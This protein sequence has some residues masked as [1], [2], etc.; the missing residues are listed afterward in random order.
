MELHKNWCLMIKLI[1][2]VVFFISITKSS[3][4]KSFPKNLKEKELKLNESFSS[5][6][7]QSHQL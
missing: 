4:E 6:C 7:T 5:M 2:Q 1:N 3:Q